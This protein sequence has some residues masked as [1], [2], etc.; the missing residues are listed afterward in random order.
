MP[1]VAAGLPPKVEL[2]VQLVRAKKHVT[3]V[4]GLEEFGVDLQVLARDLQRKYAAS[5]SVG[6]CANNPQKREVYVQGNLAREIEE[7]LVKDCG[8]KRSMLSVELGKSVKAK[9]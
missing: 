1:I 4:R 2:V 6:P 3:H 5:A 8:F 7:F 9:K